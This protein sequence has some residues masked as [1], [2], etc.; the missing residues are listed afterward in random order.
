ME[1]KILYTD[2][3]IA[4]MQLY[5]PLCQLVYLSLIILVV[6]DDVVVVTIL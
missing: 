3:S 5:K 4:C 1:Q 2:F 6:F